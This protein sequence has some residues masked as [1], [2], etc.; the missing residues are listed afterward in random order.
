MPAHM[1][2]SLLAPQAQ[3]V[4]PLGGHGRMRRAGDTVNYFVDLEVFLER[5][6]ADDCL[7]MLDRR[8]QHIAKKDVEVRQ[9]R[10]V[11]LVAKHDMSRDGLIA[12]SN[13][14]NEARSRLHSLDVGPRS[15]SIRSSAGMA[16]SVALQ[17]PAQRLQPPLGC[18]RQASRSSWQRPS[19]VLTHD[20]A[21]T[22]GTLGQSWP[23][24]GRGRRPRAWRPADA[25]HVRSCGGAAP[26]RVDRSLT[27]R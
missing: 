13:A 3:D 17:A 1:H 21:R 11:T 16:R 15:K 22:S 26:R 12:S 8:D 20:S 25:G 18:R 10:D 2:V 7:S 19:S 24:R 14:T 5:E 23:R 4:D 6:L 27:V 9:E